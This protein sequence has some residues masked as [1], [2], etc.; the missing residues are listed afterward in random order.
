MTGGESSEQFDYLIQA[1]VREVDL[2]ACKT[3][4][5]SL[6]QAALQSEGYLGQETSYR[7]LDDGFIEYNVRL[8][9]SNIQIIKRNVCRK[10]VI[11]ILFAD[12][13]LIL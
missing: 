11:S 1:Q 7:Q 3:L 6:K 13:F 5:E 2:A 9:F 12:E 10:P 8:C 4:Q